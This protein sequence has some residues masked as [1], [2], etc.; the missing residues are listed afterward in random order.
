MIHRLTICRNV[1]VDNSGQL[2][3]QRMQ[4]S[5]WQL[6]PHTTAC[7][8]TKQVQKK[9]RPQNHN[10]SHNSFAPMTKHEMPTCSS[11]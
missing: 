9:K 2:H 3:N 5:S 1:I 4:S 6:L 10:A 7:L 8:V 11:V